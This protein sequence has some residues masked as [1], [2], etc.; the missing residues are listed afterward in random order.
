MSA[1]ALQKVWY[2]ILTIVKS[3]SPSLDCESPIE[4]IVYL[5]TVLNNTRVLCGQ[6]QWRQVNSGE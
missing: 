4:T 2:R 6:R 3:N 1:E 5:F